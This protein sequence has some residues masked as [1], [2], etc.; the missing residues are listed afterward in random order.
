V[1]FTS[2]AL[3]ASI[4]F[5]NGAVIGW[6]W[7]AL[8]FYGLALMSKESG[9]AF[10][11]LIGIF[12]ATLPA[13][14]P[15]PK[16]RMLWLAA[17]V[18]CVTGLML[19]IR[20]VVLGGLGGYPHTPGAGSVHL[21]FTAST[22]RAL[23]SK[24]MPLSL[25]TVNLNYPT[26]L[27]AL[28]A[29]GAFAVTLAAAA[30]M[31]ASTAPRQRLLVLYALASA[32]PVVTIIGWLDTS[33]QHVRY[34]YMPALFVMILAAAALAT[35]R[36]AVV[37]LSAFALSNLCCGIY[38]GWVYKVTF[39]RADELAR[40]VSA[41]CSDSPGPVRVRVIGMP[42]QING[43]MF[44]QYQFQAR[45]QDQLPHATVEFADDPSCNDRFC[46]HWQAERSALVRVRDW[47]Q[48]R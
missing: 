33:A 18:L 29:I 30:I 9:Y 23:L 26:P 34:L 27:L 39:Q 7:M 32:G 43:V 40:Q 38:N 5:L 21:S 35:A 17:G 42:A 3:I 19:A 14:Q 36:G 25:L 44:S 41:D 28:A 16:G 48:R 15:R 2:L 1:M 11:L 22:I 37:L 13:E 4:D 31:G 47:P 8:G 20:A 46:Y 24:T 10:P 12:A 6:L 45:L